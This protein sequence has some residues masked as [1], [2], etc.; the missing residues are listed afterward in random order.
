M[1]FLKTSA[2]TGGRLLEMH[3]EADPHA[4]PPP[5]HTHPR[6]E[7]RLEVESGRARVILDGVQRDVGAGDVV[8]IPRG[9]SHTWWN[10]FDEPLVLKGSVE[11]GLRFE[12]M[13]E[14]IYG[15]TR[16]GRVNKRGIP[17][18]LQAAVIFTEL[19]R[20]WSPSFLPWPVRTILMPLLAIPGRLFY[21]PWYPEFS[22][23]GPAPTS[24]S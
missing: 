15:L 21:R 22:P 9:S 24:P 7:E 17:N 10:P 16:T 8:V 11:P 3:V 5:M 1:R 18:P 2:E 6:A 4:L 14:T 13:L 12:T 20:E 23:N 19:S